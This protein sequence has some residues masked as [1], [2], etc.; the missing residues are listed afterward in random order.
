MG[1]NGSFSSIP[2]EALDDSDEEMTEPAT[3]ASLSRQLRQLALNQAKLTRLVRQN[4][5]YVLR[6]HQNSDPL[7]WRKRAGLTFAGAFTGGCFMFL[8]L[9]IAVAL[10]VSGH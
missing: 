3:L 5:D 9:R 2:P 10:A 8:L 7:T 4:S 1:T 6:L